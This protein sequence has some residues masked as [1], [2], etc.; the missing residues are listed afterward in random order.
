[1]PR[2]KTTEQ[3]ISQANKAHKNAYTYT[4]TKYTTAHEKVVV[5]C[6][7]HGD[8]KVSAN[9]HIHKT[10]RQGCPKCVKE[11]ERRRL[12]DTKDSWIAKALKVHGQKYDYSK[13]DYFGTSTKVEIVCLACAK[14]FLQTPNSHIQGAGCPLCGVN[15][16]PE[17]KK[18]KEDFISDAKKVHF[19]K[20]D[21]S[22][23]EYIN[24]KRKVIVLCPSHG[25]FRVTPD[26]HLSSHQGCPKCSSQSYPE[27]L[28]QQE[29]KN[30]GIK[31]IV[32]HSFDDCVYKGTLRFD[33]FLPEHQC[34]IEYDGRQHFDSTSPYFSKDLVK[35][36]QIKNEFCVKKG[37]HLIRLSNPD[38]KYLN[39][40]LN[41]LF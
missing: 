13:V 2:K 32:E 5:T 30:R 41:Y 26:K 36:D 22:E 27:L 11:R 8:F 17:N 9:N 12:S 18:T 7:H 29:L 19:N 14:P 15:K 20:Y 3:F 37:L 23:V 1:M 21:Y 35:R 38:L 34:L 39:D 40:F 28:I 25:K 31:Y 16:F 33:F 10:K 4:K 6:R 24:C